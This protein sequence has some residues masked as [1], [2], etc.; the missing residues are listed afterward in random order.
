MDLAENVLIMRLSSIKP[1]TIALNL[2]VALY[3]EKILQ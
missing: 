3:R 2:V 1:S